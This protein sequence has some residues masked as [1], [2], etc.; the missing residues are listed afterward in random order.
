[1][2]FSISQALQFAIAGIPMFGVDTCGFSG[3]S[4][5]EL[6]SRWMQ[7]SAFFPFYRNH[8]VISSLAQEAYVWSS[9]ADAT[10]TVMQIRYSLLPFFYTL[11]YHAHAAGE[12]VM[13]AVA[14]EFPNDPQLAGVDNQFMLGSCLL[15]TPVLVPQA[16]TVMTVFPG[17]AQGTIWYD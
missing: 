7:L 5:Y 15:V 8:N 1:M 3:N 13:R 9:V 2:Y 17:L 11:F 4:D 12:T 14:W 16:E 10:G 6:C